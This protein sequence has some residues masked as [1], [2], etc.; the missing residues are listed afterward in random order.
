MKKNKIFSS[1]GEANRLQK[2]LKE[3]LNMLVIARKGSYD[4]KD[5][6][7]ED[8]MLSNLLA[9]WV[10]AAGGSSLPGGDGASLVL[11]GFGSRIAQKILEQ[12]PNDGMGKIL[13]EAA[14]DPKLMKILLEKTVDN[15]KYI[16]TAQNLYAW[17][18]S[19]GLVKIPDALENI[20]GEEDET[21]RMLRENESTPE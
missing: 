14:R 4:V 17:L 19:Q 16:R 7:Q 10:G 21:D 11:A 1:P 18:Y 12:L 20:G 5:K 9:R 2:V 3:S 13:V 6:F 8:S 15:D